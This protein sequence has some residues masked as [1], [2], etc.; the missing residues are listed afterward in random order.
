MSVAYAPC[1]TLTQM[2]PGNS[3]KAGTVCKRTLNNRHGR[4]RESAPGTMKR[5]MSGRYGDCA[6][7][8]DR[9]GG[10]P[11]RAEPQSV[12]R[13][14]IVRCRWER[15]GG[16]GSSRFVRRNAAPGRREG[17]RQAWSRGI[18]GAAPATDAVPP[19]RRRTLP[20]FQMEY[21]GT[22]TTTRIRWPSR[23]GEETWRGSVAVD[24]SRV[25]TRPKSLFRS[26]Q[27][28]LAQNN[29]VRNF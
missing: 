21:K 1:L 2:V 18:L 3:S 9:R 12:L 26:C 13:R 11:S 8:I 22:R 4:D 23:R 17:R 20:Q 10:E 15:R 14:T 25:W 27:Q 16:E 29:H 19:E 28:S 7:G 24:T 6:E 5:S